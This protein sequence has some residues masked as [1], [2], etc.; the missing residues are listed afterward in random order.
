M[1]LRDKQARP[2]GETRTMLPEEVQEGGGI[3]QAIHK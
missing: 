3:R 1:E 2:E